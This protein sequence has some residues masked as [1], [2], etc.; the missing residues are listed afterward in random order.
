[1]AQFIVRNLEDD[2]HERLRELAK[3]HGKSL[4]ELVREV[5]RRFALE[6]A[7]PKEHLGTRISKRFAK[8][9]LE[10]PIEEL[11]GQSVS[12]PSFE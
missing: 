9:G 4:E 1:M 10:E 7:E 3:S 5:L 12:P 8:I 2:I 6:R 11:R